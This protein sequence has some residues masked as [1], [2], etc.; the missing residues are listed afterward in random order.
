MPFLKYLFF[1]SVLLSTGNISSQEFPVMAFHGV[2]PSYTGVDRFLQMKEAG[3][4]I[5]MTAYENN[6]QAEQALD[7][8]HK[9]GVKILLLTPELIH[10]T[11]KTVLR[12][13]DHPA[14]FGYFVSDEPGATHFAAV[15]QKVNEIRALD[16]HRPC[17]VNLYPNYAESDQ[18]ESSS[19]SDYLKEYERQIDVSFISFDHYPVVNN[20]IRPEWFANLELIRKT[21]I[22]QNKRFWGFAN[23]TVF[24]PYQ[25]PT[26]AGL[27][28]QVFANLLYGAQGIQYFSYWTLNDAAWRKNHFGHS[29]VDALGEPTVTFNVVRTVNQELQQFAKVFMGGT[30]EAV[31][32]TDN[33]LP[34]QTLRVPRRLYGATQISTLGSAIVAQIR[35]KGI[36]YTSIL[37]KD[38]HRP[39]DLA[40]TSTVR[41][42]SMGSKPQVYKAGARIRFMLQPGEL[43][44]FKH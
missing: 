19:Y 37:N 20:T 34:Q 44:I 36:I 14:L 24:G 39:L 5:N 32:H 38:L 6:F 22:L 33:N 18:L 2:P 3:F 30:I 13:R 4:N 26:L 21:A 31:Y 25:Q 41:T 35:N 10:E 40:F 29:I 17:Y 23:A 28:L 43:K 27:R 1:F 7:A 9:A 12:F 8:A 15:A 11:T 42:E 16:P